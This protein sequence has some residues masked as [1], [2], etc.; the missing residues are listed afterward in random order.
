MRRTRR[1]SVVVLLI[2]FVAAACGSSGKGG[3]GASSST[4]TAGGQKNVHL[5]VPGVTDDEIR[6]AVIGTK[7]NNPLGSCILDCYT[8]GVKAYFAVRN[9]DGGIYGRKLTV[10][11]VLDDELTKNQQ[12]AL[13][14]VSD[15]DVFGDFNATLF[16]SGWGDLSKAGVPSFTWGINF[17]ESEGR[18][19][20]FPSLASSCG[21]C[22]GRLVP[23]TAM[24]VHAKRAATL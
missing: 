3:D 24:S 7:A 12:R 20:I 22:T 2:V 14:V 9:A 23:W 4:T 16:A 11:K 5:D 15:N 10:S 8:A 17:A 21:T 13:E 18:D 6:F 1:S 19:N